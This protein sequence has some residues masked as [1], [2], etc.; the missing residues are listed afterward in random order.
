MKHLLIIFSLLL[1]SVSWSKDEY[2]CSQKYKLS[3]PLVGKSKL[4]IDTDG[5]WVREKD[6]K[7]TKDKITIFN[8]KSGG[9]MILGSLTPVCIWKDIIS[10]IENTKGLVLKTSYI[11]ND[12]CEYTITTKSGNTKDGTFN[13]RTNTRLYRKGSK[14]YIK[15][16]GGV[17]GY[18]SSGDYCRKIVR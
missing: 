5:E 16:Y 14:V 11:T 8:R 18:A 9:V 4:F 17:G 3:D 13:I 7:I 1:T 2:Y 6:V 10:R 15:R 12:T